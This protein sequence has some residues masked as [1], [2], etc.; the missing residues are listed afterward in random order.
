MKTPRKLKCDESNN[1]IQ[2]FGKKTNKKQ[3]RE[4]IS[5]KTTNSGSWNKTYHN[6]RYK[7]NNTPKIGKQTPTNF[8]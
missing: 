4:G 6:N 8:I 3:I 7:L 1:F 5:N 2:I